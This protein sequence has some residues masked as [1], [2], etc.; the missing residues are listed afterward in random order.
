MDS[1][2]RN[3]Y[4]AVAAFA[5]LLLLTVWRRPRLGGAHTG[6]TSTRGTAP[7]AAADLCT[8]VARSLRGQKGFIFIKTHKTAGSTLSA[9]LWRK[10]CEV[11]R[12]NCFLPPHSNPGRIWSLSKD[13][14]TIQT[15]AGSGNRSYPFDAWLHHV[16][17]SDRLLDVVPAARLRV[18]I[19]RKPSQRFQSAWIWY[20]HARRLKMSLQTFIEKVASKQISACRHRYLPRL[21]QCYDF[22]YRTGLDATSGELVGLEAAKLAGAALHPK[23]ERLLADVAAG[24]VLLLVADR[25]DQSLVVLALLAEWP[26]HQLLY[27]SKKVSSHNKSSPHF[28]LST[29]AAE[30][31]DRVQPLDSALYTAATT[32]LERYT[33]CLGDGLVRAETDRFRKALARLSTACARP[34]AGEAALCE[35]LA[36]DNREIVQRWRPGSGRRVAEGLERFFV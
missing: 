34:A 29:Q 19:V 23:F 15:S 26:L 33:H 32:M 3:R 16:H 6:R 36:R 20:D 7:A 22:K 24:R 5:V 28:S 18:S 13:W 27:L 12:L 35:R 9:V 30:L 2:W 14:A 4:L 8:G 31:A 25:F 21:F 17:Y 10:L 1:A 11:E